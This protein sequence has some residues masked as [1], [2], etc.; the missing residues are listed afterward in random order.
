[1]LSAPDGPNRDQTRNF[2]PVAGEYDL[3]ALLHQIKQLAELVLRLESTDLA[4]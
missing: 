1:L 3:F 4:H 2:L